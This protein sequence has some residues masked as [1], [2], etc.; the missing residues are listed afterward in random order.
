MPQKNRNNLQENWHQ[1]CSLRFFC[2]L[3]FKLLHIYFLF[4]LFLI[5]TPL[6]MYMCVCIYI[7]IYFFVV[8]GAGAGLPSL[9]DLS[10]P[11]RE[12]NPRPWQWELGV[13]TTG[14]PGNSH[15]SP[16]FFVCIFLSSKVHAKNSFNMLPN[17]KA[18]ICTGAYS[19]P[20]A[21]V[22]QKWASIGQNS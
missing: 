9:W 5:P 12:S 8:G 15:P 7:H 17:N 10:S 3:L 6:Y 16:S 13:V 14:T 18:T 1:R 4:I 19:V 2:C 21:F 11:T 20:S 22:I